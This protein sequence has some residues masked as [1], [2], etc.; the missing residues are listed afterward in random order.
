[1]SNVFNKPDLKA[2]RYREKRFGLLNKETISEFKEQYPS[3][4]NIDNEKLKSIVKLYNVKLWNTVIENRDGVQLPDSLGYLFIGTCPASKTGNTDYALSNKY[5][6]VIKNKNWETDG[7]IGKI[8]YTNWSAKYRYKNR[9]LWKFEACR[10]FKREVAKTYPENWTK[11]IK[12]KNTFRVA[13]FYTEV[14]EKTKKELKSYN[15]FED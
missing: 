15:E 3:Y 8:F 9:D 13:K 7:N 1:M 10:E 12:V 6:K 2:P 11:Y 4:S 14:N 5:G